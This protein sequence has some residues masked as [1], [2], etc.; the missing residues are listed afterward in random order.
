[1]CKT[2]TFSLNHQF[3]CWS[4]KRP[5][6]VPWRSWRLGRRVPAGLLLYLLIELLQ[7]TAPPENASVT[8][9]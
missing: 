9:V 8:L 7:Y 1:M 2:R 4:P 5:L 3:F 6:K